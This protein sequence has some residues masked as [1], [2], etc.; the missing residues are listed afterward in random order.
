MTTTEELLALCLTLEM[1]CDNAAINGG[2]D[3]DHHAEL[4]ELINGVRS[5]LKS[6]GDE[7]I[8]DAPDCG[9]NSCE[10]A[11]KKGGMRTNGGCRCLK[12]VPRETRRYF[13][14]LHRAHKQPPSPRVRGGDKVIHVE[15]VVPGPINQC[16]G[17]ALGYPVDTRG[18]HI[19]NDTNSPFYGK[20]YMSCTKHVYQDT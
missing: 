4:R 13:T 6:R 7:S 15:V 8:G 18:L 17:C 10:F 20:C 1:D 3:S 9:D 16:D 12:D 19:N 11:K 5:L 2:G 14:L